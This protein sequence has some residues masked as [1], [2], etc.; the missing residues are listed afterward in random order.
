MTV[1]HSNAARS[2]AADAV[3]AL[4]DGGGTIVYLTVAD[5]IVA[6]GNLSSDAYA[7]AVNGVAGNNAIGDDTNAVGGTATKVEIR[8]SGNNLVFGGSVGPPASGADIEM[9]PSNVVTAGATVQT[10]TATYTAAP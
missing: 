4:P 10:S 7:A 6:T 5:A 2:A 9:S 1:S 3:C 8:D